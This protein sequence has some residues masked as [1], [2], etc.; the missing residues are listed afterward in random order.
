[1]F[2]IEFHSDIL[3]IF[4]MRMLKKLFQYENTSSASLDN[5][6]HLRKNFLSLLENRILTFQCVSEVMPKLSD[7]VE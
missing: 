5:R 2:L 4:T 7:S 6:F 1:M 3:Y